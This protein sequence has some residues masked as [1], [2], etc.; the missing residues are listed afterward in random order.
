MQ[1]HDLTSGDLV[2]QHPDTYVAA[3]TAKLA[4]DEQQRLWRSPTEE[5]VAHG[6]VIGDKPSS[7]RKRFAKA[8]VWVVPPPSPT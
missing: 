4:R 1:M 2:A 5:D 3:I 6:E 8:A 7:R